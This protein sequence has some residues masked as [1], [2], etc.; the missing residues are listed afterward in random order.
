ME[1]QEAWEVPEALEALEDLEN[2]ENLGNL[3]DLEDLENLVDLEVVE[4]GEVLETMEA[5]RERGGWMLWKEQV[6]GADGHIGYNHEAQPDEAGAGSGE[7]AVDKCKLE[8]SITD[9]DTTTHSSPLLASQTPP[10]LSNSKEPNLS[11]P[12]SLSS[13][14]TRHKDHPPP[15]GADNLGIESP[16]GDRHAAGQQEASEEASTFALCTPGFFDKLVDDMLEAL[17][18][19]GGVLP[20]GTG[21]TEPGS[22]TGDRHAAGQSQGGSGPTQIRVGEEA[23]EEASEEAAGSAG[24]RDGSGDRLGSGAAK[25][26]YF[27]RWSDAGKWD[28]DEGEEDE[29]ATLRAIQAEILSKGVIFTLCTPSFFDKLLDDTLESLDLNP[30]WYEDEQLLS[31]EGEVAKIRAGADATEHNK[32]PAPEGAVHSMV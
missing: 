8:S 17:D 22:T 13:D 10:D 32:I 9:S 6:G 2:L 28:E 21:S 3:E 25:G 18:P 24:V 15:Q 7:E 5:R 4:A 26:G 16:T 19:Q 23:S 31:V 30:Q 11:P 1:A 14:G 27:D 12:T 29:E 20:L